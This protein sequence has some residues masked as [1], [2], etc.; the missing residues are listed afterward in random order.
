MQARSA[1]RQ[2]RT[3]MGNLDRNKIP[4]P[5]TWS[6][7]ERL[8]LEAWKNWIEWEKSNPLLLDNE[9]VLYSRIIYA[10]RQAI[11]NLRFYPEIWYSAIEYAKSKGKDSEAMEF[12][13]NGIK[14]NKLSFLLHYQLASSEEENNRITEARNT[15]ELLISNIGQE[16]EKMNKMAEFMK[17]QL[18]TEDEVDTNLLS[19]VP[20]SEKEVILERK[21]K[22]QI[23]RE[24]VNKEHEARAE[25]IA[26][27][28]TNA[29]IA[30]MNAVRRVEGVKSARQI[31]AKARKM[32][33][34]SHHIFVAS[35]IFFGGFH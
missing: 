23:Q 16:Y 3:I 29:W 24:M 14:A 5:P 6:P 18:N 10:Y 21:Q 9:N 20:E 4:R 7:T 12:M 31:F 8:E 35:G 13:K 28:T 2:M 15:L 19:T 22:R 25:N 30:M 1:L 33:P 34:L 17:L 32:T 26:N 27:D 11:M